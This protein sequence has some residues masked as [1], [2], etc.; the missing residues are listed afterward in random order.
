L[1]PD[2]SRQATRHLANFA[3]YWILGPIQGKGLQSG[4]GVG[5]GRL[6]SL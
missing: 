4:G 1:I 6:E 2:E 3:R 5:L